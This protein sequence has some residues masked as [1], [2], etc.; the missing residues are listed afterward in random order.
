MK[1]KVFISQS[2]ARSLALA[3]ALQGFVRKLVQATDPW[4][5]RTG[6]ATELD[7]NLD[8]A[9]AGIVCLTSDNLDARWI[10]FEA[11]AL[12]RTGKKVWTVLLDVEPADVVPSLSQFQ[13]TRAGEGR[14]L[15]D[16]RDD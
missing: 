13:H 2:G 6:I 16:G 9:G 7:D 3:E 10:L 5:S 8:Q 4:V 11:G 1:T 12:S 15:A 14:H